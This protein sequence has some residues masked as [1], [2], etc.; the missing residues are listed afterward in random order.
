MSHA[1]FKRL[2]WVAALMLP[3]L[4]SLPGS[5]AAAQ[6]QNEASAYGGEYERQ[7]RRHHRRHKERVIK[8]HAVT[9]SNV[10]KGNPLFNWGEPYGPF[11]LTHLGVYNPAGPEPL[12][13]DEN[14]LDSAVLAT[15]VDPNVLQVGGA[16]P[17]DVKPEWINVPLR[18]I[19]VNTDFAFVVKGPLLGALSSRPI[20]QSQVEPAHEITL[21]EWMK[22]RGVVKISCR[23]GRATV[24]LRVRD[25]LPNRQ[26]SVWATMGLPRDGSA[27]TFFP[28][29]F[30]GTPNLLITDKYGDAHFKRVINYCPFEPD[31]TRRPLLTI[32]V[33][34]HGN[35]QSYGGVPEPAF[36]HGWWPGLVT[37][38]Q[39]QF[40]INVELLE[41][42][43][44]R[45]Q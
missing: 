13:I 10:V 27:Q 7:H 42:I 34:F 25:L 23:G 6:E 9:G 2:L 8:G 32:S 15:Y 44:D 28:V 12:P 41:P 22:A 16:T 4:L 5:Q 17:E 40:P 36:I 1:T 38:T 11:T 24:N 21:G 35:H 29:P 33:Q 39:L 20:Q 18:Q 14:T 26:Y 45:E 43:N 19:A 31:S 30:G 3:G 37:F